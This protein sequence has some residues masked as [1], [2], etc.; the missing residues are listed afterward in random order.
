ML[1]LPL[2]LQGSLA[3]AALIRLNAPR[4]AAIPL[5]RGAAEARGGGLGVSIYRAIDED[6]KMS[7]LPYKGAALVATTL[8]GLAL[9]LSVVGLYGVM[10]FAVNQRV[11][12]IGIRVAL[13][14]TGRRIVQLFV[15]QG[16]RLVAIGLVV[17]SLGAFAMPV[18]LSRIIVGMRPFDPW[19]LLCVMVLLGLATL[20]ACWLPAR[21]A[22]K[23]DPMVALR[24]E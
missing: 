10:A 23:V 20:A 8:G 24:A 6:R 4:E 18:V 9:L 5:I 19:P 2:P 21:R 14:A 17:G 16:I 15:R 13:G 7:L 22:T 11:R 12:E 3:R 1:Y